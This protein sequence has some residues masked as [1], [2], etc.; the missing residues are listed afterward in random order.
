MSNQNATT[1]EIE[2]G[3]RKVT[4]E[5]G[6]FCELSSGSCLVRCGETAVLV[7][8]NMSETPRPGIDFFP[9]GVDFE[10]KM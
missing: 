8:V 3:G 7:N 4:F 6:K 2:V 10:E 5:T 1:F 9:L